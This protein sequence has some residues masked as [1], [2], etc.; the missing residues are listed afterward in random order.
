[1]LPAALVLLAACA[2]VDPTLTPVEQGRVLYDTY[3][4]ECHGPRAVGTREGPG[5][6]D[7]RSQA[8][9]MSDAEFLDATVNGVDAGETEFAGMAAIPAVDEEEAALITLY[10]RDLQRGSAIPSGSSLP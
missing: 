5:L 4:A 7:A 2:S 10:I 6:L 1:M 9:S 8:D 3:C